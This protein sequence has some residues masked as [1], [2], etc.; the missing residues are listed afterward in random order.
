[1]STPLQPLVRVT[2]G[3]PCPSFPLTILAFWCLTEAQMDEMADWY[4]Q[5]SPCE[6][7]HMYPMRMG[8]GDRE[9]EGENGENGGLW[10]R[11]AGLETKRRRV[12]RFVGLRG[13]ESP[14]VEDRKEGRKRANRRAREEE[15][16]AMRKKWV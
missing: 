16:R 10:E 3:L 7:T 12:G 2:T 13:C 15:E 1:M 8:R 5:A 14:V 6:W 11:E 9:G 4:H